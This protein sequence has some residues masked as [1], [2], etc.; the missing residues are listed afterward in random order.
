MCGRKNT[1]FLKRGWKNSM[2]CFL[3]AL[4]FLLLFHIYWQFFKMGCSTDRWSYS[5][6]IH[7]D[8]SYSDFRPTLTFLWKL[9]KSKILKEASDMFHSFL[10]LAD[11]ATGVKCY[12]G[13]QK[14]HQFWIDHLLIELH[15]NTGRKM[16]DVDAKE[17]FRKW[18]VYYVVTTLGNKE[19]PFI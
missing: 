9:M 4:Y 12:P 10:L 18:K 13:F 14:C 6:R 8:T 16:K 3:I 1:F 7:K 5:V 19:S 11:Q 17:N 15:T 2:F